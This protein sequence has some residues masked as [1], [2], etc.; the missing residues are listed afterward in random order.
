MEDNAYETGASVWYM[1]AG[2]A[3]HGEVIGMTHEEDTDSW[4]YDVKDCQDGGV[5]ELEEYELFATP[6]TLI[7]D[8]FEDF[9]VEDVDIE[10]I[11]F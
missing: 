4:L 6:E 3:R 9:E 7:R 2:K 10:L 5:T 1:E 8:V 11:P